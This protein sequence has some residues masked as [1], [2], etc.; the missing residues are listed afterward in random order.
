VTP[1]LVERDFT[2][3]GPNQRST[4]DKFAF[5]LADGG[6]LYLAA[7]VDLHSSREPGHGGIEHQNQKPRTWNCFAPR[8]H[9]EDVVQAGSASRMGRVVGGG[10]SVPARCRSSTS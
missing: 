9:Q 5:A 2:A 4:G 6:T 8:D 7:N 10:S 1:N 3:A